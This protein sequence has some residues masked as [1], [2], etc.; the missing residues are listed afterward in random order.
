M[1]PFYNAA[2]ATPQANDDIP[3]FQARYGARRT[4]APTPAPAAGRREDGGP[5]RVT[6]NGRRAGGRDGARKP[7]V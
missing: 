6:S 1:A 4:P 7:A 5:T 2:I 3:R